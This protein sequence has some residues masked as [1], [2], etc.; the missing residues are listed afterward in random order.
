MRYVLHLFTIDYTQSASLT[1]LTIQVAERLAYSER[2]NIA[3]TY[4]EDGS[5][6]VQDYNKVMPPRGL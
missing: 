4:K 5:F 6:T 2:R 1:H 3:F